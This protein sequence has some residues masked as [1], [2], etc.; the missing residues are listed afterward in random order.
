MQL[1]LQAAVYL[2]FGL[3]AVQAMAWPVDIKV[4]LFRSFAPALNYLL[5]RT[6][7][8]AFSGCFRLEV[9]PWY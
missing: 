5:A 4:I 2:G 3:L 7:A 9:L 1:Q 8:H 6:Y